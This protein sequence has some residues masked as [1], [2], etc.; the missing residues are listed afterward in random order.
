MKKCLEN[1]NV[2]EMFQCVINC[3]ELCSSTCD[4]DVLFRSKCNVVTKRGGGGGGLA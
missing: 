1:L 2:E 3:M 4:C